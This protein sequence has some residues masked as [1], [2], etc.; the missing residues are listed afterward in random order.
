[1]SLYVR[2]QT[3]FYTHRKTARLRAK[4]GD[5]ALWLVP[6]LWCYAAENQPDGDF[7]KYESTELALLLGYNK[8]AC[9]MLEALQQAEFLDGMKVHSWDEHNAYHA[10]FSDRAKKAASAR[11]AGKDK[12]GKERIGKEKS[13]N[14]SSNASSINGNSS[15][16][17]TLIQAI[18]QGVLAGIPED[19]ARYVHDD[20]HS[21]E[22]KDGA[23]VK[24][25][26]IRHAKKRWN[27]EGQ[28][29]QAGKHKGNGNGKKKEPES[30]L[31]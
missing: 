6:R 8:D 5:D 17:L 24:C 7:S 20:W 21:R 25:D 14:D 13:K 30:R 3:S 23:G 11:W 2:L 18:S 15:E 16:V 1:M 31:I 9:V 19:F 10:V 27:R 28:E 22:G 29:W 26:F 4:L 12:K